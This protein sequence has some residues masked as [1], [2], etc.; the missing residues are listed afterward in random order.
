VGVTL[1]E[2]KEHKQEL[3]D[4]TRLTEEQLDTIL[5]LLLS[6][7]L[8]VDGITIERMMNEAKNMMDDI[9]PDDTPFMALALAVENDGI[10]SDDEHFEQQNRMRVWKTKELLELIK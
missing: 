4:K 10:W 7:I 2:I 9:D 6:R 1:E 5:A 3:L 8:I